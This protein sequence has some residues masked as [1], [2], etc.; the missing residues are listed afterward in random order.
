MKLRLIIIDILFVLLVAS[1]NSN[2]KVSCN[3]H[4]ISCE[5][6]NFIRT[7]ERG[8]A[9]G[10]MGYIDEE[11]WEKGGEWDRIRFEVSK[12]LDTIPD[13]RKLRYDVTIDST[14]SFGFVKMNFEIYKSDDL[15]AYVEFRFFHP[16]SHFGCKIHSIDHRIEVDY[17]KLKLIHPV[18]K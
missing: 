8:K 18:T 16:D 15:K 6:L 9:E 2:S 7:D 13:L 12:Y 10:L 17:K 4:E 1:C 14:N 5:A 3:Y 11:F